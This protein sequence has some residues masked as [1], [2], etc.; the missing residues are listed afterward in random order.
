MSS[1]AFSPQHTFGVVPD[2]DVLT[3][4]NTEEGTDE[5]HAIVTNPGGKKLLDKLYN[6]ETPYDRI[7]EDKYLR[8]IYWSHRNPAI[9]H[10]E[11][12]VHG[13]D[14]DAWGVQ[15]GMKRLMQTLP[16]S[17]L[18][19]Q[20]AYWLLHAVD[21]RHAGS[22]DSDP[23]PMFKRWQALQ[24]TD[25]FNRHREGDAPGLDLKEE[26]LV[27]LAA[28]YGWYSTNAPDKKM[29]IIYLGGADDADL[30]LRCAW[31]SD[32]RKLTQEQMQ[33]GYDRDGDAFLVAA[34]YNES[35]FWDAKKRAMLEGFI[36]GRLIHRYRRRCEQIKKK[37]PEFDLAPV[38]EQG[39]TLFD[40]EAPPPTEDQKRIE[41]VE[42]TLAAATRQLQSVYKVLLWVLI[43]VI[44][45]LV[46]IWHPHF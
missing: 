46:M 29:K 34:M 2:E 16:V 24:L 25:E 42:I 9:N 30:L 3:F 31:Y 10:D 43:L 6:A 40:D 7:P 4:I 11:S 14:M 12:S 28:V 22:F 15:K 23:T 44:V 13:P 18:G 39:A 32:E 27:M 36:S 45:A 5:L 26:F 21:P 19:L 37:H 41:R 1:A 20:T 17:E 35:I 38:S 33:S 8:A